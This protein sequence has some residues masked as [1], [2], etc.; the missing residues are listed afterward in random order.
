MKPSE[1]AY[2]MEHN[3]PFNRLRPALEEACL[4]E[5]VCL[6]SEISL[7]GRLRDVEVYSIAQH[8]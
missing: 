1:F 4:V 3:S 5:E 7:R 8:M 6:H 2:R